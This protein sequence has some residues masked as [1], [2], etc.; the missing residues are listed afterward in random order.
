MRDSGSWL[1]VE[2]LCDLDLSLGRQMSI[3]ILIFGREI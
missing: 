2:R 1:E 3:Y